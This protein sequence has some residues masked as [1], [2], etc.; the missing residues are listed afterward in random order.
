[1]DGWGYDRLA[2]AFVVE[3]VYKHKDRIEL[4]NHSTFAVCV[5]DLDWYALYFGIDCGSGF[6]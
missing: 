6:A 5:Y 1:M 3:F 2:K 4:N